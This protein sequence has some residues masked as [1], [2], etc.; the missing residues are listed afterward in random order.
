MSQYFAGNNGA[1]S[2][3]AFCKGTWGN[4]TGTAKD[5]ICIVGKTIQDPRGPQYNSHIVPC[6]KV[7]IQTTG[8]LGHWGYYCAPAAS[9]A[10]FYAGNNGTVS[11][12][13]F[14]KTSSTNPQQLSCIAGKTIIDPRGKQYVDQH[15]PCDAV[16]MDIAHG[17]GHWGYY[18]S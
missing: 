18:C 10:M 7:M 14:C 9:P 5:L 13:N 6:N 15:V 4:P 17:K 2:G 3:D 12:N 1:I 8:A 16:M 11:G